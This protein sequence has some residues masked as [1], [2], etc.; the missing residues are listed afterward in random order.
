MYRLLSQLKVF[1]IFLPLNQKKRYNPELTEYADVRATPM[2]LILV[3][4]PLQRLNLLPAG[5]RHTFV[6]VNI[7]NMILLVYASVLS[8]HSV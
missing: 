1:K 8:F 7:R 3:E 6:S 4:L 2:A 5:I